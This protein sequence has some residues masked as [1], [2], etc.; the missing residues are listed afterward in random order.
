MIK[1]SIVHESSAKIHEHLGDLT[2]N[3]P[4]IKKRIFRFA[5]AVIVVWSF[6]EPARAESQEPAFKHLSVYYQERTKGDCFPQDRPAYQRD[7]FGMTLAGS[8]IELDIT[9]TPHDESLSP[10]FYQ[11]PIDSTWP[12]D[13][14]L[15]AG[16]KVNGEYRPEAGLIE[17]MKPQYYRYVSQRYADSLRQAGDPR[18]SRWG[19]DFF[20]RHFILTIPKDISVDTVYFRAHW[21]IEGLGERYGWSPPLVII[22]PCSEADQERLLGNHIMVNSDAGNYAE[23]VALADSMIARGWSDPIGL[24]GAAISANQAG[25]YEKRLRYLDYMFSTKGYIVPPSQSSQLN[26]PAWIEWQ[27]Q[28][29]ERSRAECQTKINEQQR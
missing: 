8:M 16:H 10:I 12:A 26:D 11:M 18:A 4:N 20:K 28:A 21:K 7:E 5:L 15:D 9:A 6:G 19:S 29:Y 1:S 25:D 14:S 23:A 13:L 17:R 2:M 27:R 3:G 22:A 24:Y